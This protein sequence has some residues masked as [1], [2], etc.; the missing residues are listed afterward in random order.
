MS[1]GSFLVSALRRLY[2]RA[3]MPYLSLFFA[4]PTPL[5]APQ[6]KRHNNPCV[7]PFAATD[8]LFYLFSG[9]SRG[10]GVLVFRLCPSLP[11]GPI[12]SF[13]PST[14]TE[15][16]SSSVLNPL[17]CLFFFAAVNVPR[18]PVLSE[19]HVQH[20]FR[21]THARYSCFVRPGQP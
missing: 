13:S 3:I 7:S 2:P 15:G 21:A 11:T 20:K 5:L 18:S 10:P 12:A 19:N 14:K 8:P 17:A 1:L 6:Q 16:L 9:L 4:P